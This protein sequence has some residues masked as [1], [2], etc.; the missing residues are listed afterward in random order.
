MLL[1]YYRPYWIHL[2]RGW[3]GILFRATLVAIYGLVFGDL[4]GLWQKAMK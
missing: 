3:L 4:N 1:S 2:K